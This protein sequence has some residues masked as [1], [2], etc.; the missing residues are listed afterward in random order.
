[1]IQGQHT[2]SQP[3]FKLVLGQ[4][5]YSNLV[6]CCPRKKSGAVPDFLVGDRRTENRANSER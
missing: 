6:M 2:N 1:M 4:F 5:E 3:V